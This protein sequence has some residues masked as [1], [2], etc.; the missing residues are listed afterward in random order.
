[1]K[2]FA[3]GLGLKQR[4]K[5]TRKWPITLTGIRAAIHQ[6]LTSAPDNQGYQHLIPVNK[7]TKETNPKPAQESSIAAE[8]MLKLR[9]YLVF[10][11]LF[12]LVY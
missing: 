4:Q 10:L 9:Q 6:Q 7:Q 3:L 11:V 2:D 8:N 12:G 1:M 5:A